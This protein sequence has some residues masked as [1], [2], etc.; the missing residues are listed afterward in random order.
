MGTRH[1]WFLCVALVMTIFAR[2]SAI[3]FSAVSDAE[4]QHEEAV[5]FDFADE[6]IVAYAVFPEFT[7]ER[8]VQGL[9]DA[10]WVIEA[11]YSG[12]EETQDAAAMLRVEFAE[13][14][15]NGRRKFNGVGH[16]V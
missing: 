5:V 11:G 6:S 1:G 14:P 12:V 3:D 8:A 9:T 13:F 4:D 2:S 10:A 7:E 16:D 15:V